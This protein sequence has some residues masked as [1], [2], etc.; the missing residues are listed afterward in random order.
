M[1]KVRDYIRRRA[2]VEGRRITE[3]QLDD[4]TQSLLEY[5]EEILEG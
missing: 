2:E 5:C 1:E 4:L 3:R